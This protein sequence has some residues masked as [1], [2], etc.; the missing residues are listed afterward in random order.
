MLL[1]LVTVLQDSLLLPKA[2]TV[3][4]GLNAAAAAPQEIKLWDMIVKGG[5]LMIPLGIL[6]VI[7][8]Y[9]FV[10]RYLT[11]SRAG[12]LENNFM[13][14]VRDHITSG[15][16]SAARSLSKNTAGPIAR[17]IDKGIQRI[18]KP[19]DA[20]EKSMEN[21]G[22]LEIYKMEKNL[23]ILAII[24]GIAPMFG[25]LGTI[26]GMI[27]T[28]FNISQTSDIT[29]S[30]IA[31]GIYVKMVTSAAGLI[32]GLVAYIG[33]SF[34]QAQIDKVINKMEGASSEFID[35]LLEPSK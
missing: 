15:N 28:F 14:M 17:M 20:I 26:A 13:P 5:P 18:G 16:I 10:E 29:L 1:G 25:F 8:V 32:I 12:K 7:A 9:V 3:A 30:T 6:S 24:A 23:V 2:D 4:A 21:V 34:L 11:I 35:V 33:Y 31:G 22:K 19:T 27:Q